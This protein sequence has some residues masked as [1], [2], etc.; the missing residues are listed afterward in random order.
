MGLDGKAHPA[1][2]LHHVA[3]AS[4]GPVSRPLLP[5]SE[6]R[7]CKIS[8][9]LNSDYPPLCFYLWLFPSLYLSY[10]FFF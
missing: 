5:S 8:A 7:K 4:V 3:R 1:R 9:N 2:Y 10:Q 6:F